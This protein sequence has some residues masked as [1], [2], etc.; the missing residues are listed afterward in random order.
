[1]VPNKLNISNFFLSINFIRLIT[2]F[3]EHA[4]Q[5]SRVTKLEGLP[6]Y[7]LSPDCGFSREL[8]VSLFLSSKI[9]MPCLQLNLT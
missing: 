1:M 5:S 9:L 7:Q 8:D 3:F 2:F 6:A 4:E